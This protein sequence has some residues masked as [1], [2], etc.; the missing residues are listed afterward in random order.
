MEGHEMRAFLDKIRVQ[1]GEYMSKMSRK[2][3]IQ[4]AILSVVVITLAIVTVSILSRTQYV[5]LYPAQTPAEAGEI[6]MVLRE[7]GVPAEVDGT[8]ILVPENSAA[9]LR[10]LLSA[11]GV[12]GPEDLNRELLDS[13]SGF[14]VTDS[15]AKKLYE[16]QRASEIRT[17]LLAIPRIQNAIVIV[18]FGET[19]PFRIATGTRDAT[20]AVM[21]TLRDNNMLS[22]QE[23]QTI[24]EYVRGGVPGIRYENISITDNNIRSYRVTEDDGA[25]DID[26]EMDFRIALQNRLTEQ[27]QTQAEQLLTPIFGMSNVKVTSTVRLN[28]DRIVEDSVEF[29]PPVAGEL[30]GIVRSSSELYE[31]Q[32]RDEAAAGIPG[33]DTNLGPI[34]YPYGTLGDGDLYRKALIEK[35]YEINETRR[36]IEREQGKLEFISIGVLFNSDSVDEDYKDEVTNLVSV[37]LGIPRSNVAVESTPFKEHDTRI[38][39]MYDAW[40]AFQR[41]QRQQEFVEFIIKC[42]VVLLLGLAVIFLIATIVRAVKPPPEPEPALVGYGIDYIAGDDYDEEE[43]DEEIHAEEV[44]ELQTKSTGL[45]MIE[46]FIDKDPAAVAQL[47]RNWLTDE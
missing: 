15:H 12:L 35:N 40:E 45:E 19:S 7:M 33:T 1:L 31:L 39:G 25:L 5:T 36:V 32:R 46:K 24:A 13:A 23:A 4:L 18:N 22:P 10:V 42:A 41:E 38:Q 26:T 20:A 16:A 21:L 14:S 27:V 3:K 8:R 30:D 9:E 11:Q 6:L 44:F 29:N 47:L 43:Y 2:S 28:F 37:G 17:A 34:E